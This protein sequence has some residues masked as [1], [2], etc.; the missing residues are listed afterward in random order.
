MGFDWDH[1]VVDLLNTNGIWHAMRVGKRRYVFV[2]KHGW[3]T[4]FAH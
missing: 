3:G 2:D 1:I 4:R